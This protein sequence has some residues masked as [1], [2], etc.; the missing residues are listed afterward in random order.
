MPLRALPLDAPPLL[1]GALRALLSTS[2]YTKCDGLMT[3][4]PPH[5]VASYKLG[6]NAHV[7]KPVEL[8]EFANAVKEWGVFWAIINESPPESERRA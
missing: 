4:A 8:H 6:V 3:A 2:G 7:V 1:G 5:T